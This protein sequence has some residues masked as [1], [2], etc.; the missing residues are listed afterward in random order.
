[1]VAESFFNTGK[2]G[3]YGNGF[4]GNGCALGGDIKVKSKGLCIKESQY[5]CAVGGNGGA[6]VKTGHFF[7]EK[8]HRQVQSIVYQ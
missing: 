8:V 6:E 7:S 2:S 3:R 4:K 5:I 1:M